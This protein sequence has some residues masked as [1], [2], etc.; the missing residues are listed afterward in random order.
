M[1]IAHYTLVSFSKSFGLVY[2]LAMAAVQ[3][4]AMCLS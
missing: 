4:T 3:A 2:L 1:D